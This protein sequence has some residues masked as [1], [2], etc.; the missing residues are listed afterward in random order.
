MHGQSAEPRSDA[1]DSANVRQQAASPE[2]LGLNQSQFSA[3][4][5][6]ERCHARVSGTDS[7]HRIAQFGP[8]KATF[9]GFLGARQRYR[10]SA[11]RLPIRGDGRQPC[12]L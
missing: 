9:L 2:A 10:S 8:T 5:V 11:M 6:S 1:A 12:C 4:L 3:R 7:A